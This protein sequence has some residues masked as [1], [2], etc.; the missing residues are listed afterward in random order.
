MKWKLELSG[1]ANHGDDGKSPIL[2]C[3]DVGRIVSATVNTWTDNYPCFRLNVLSELG[4]FECGHKYSY[5]VGAA[6][7]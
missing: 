7:H 6:R 2:V 3:E 4:Y 5:M 1:A